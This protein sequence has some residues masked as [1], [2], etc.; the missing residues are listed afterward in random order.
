M[1]IERGIITFV[2]KKNKKL[3]EWEKTGNICYKIKE[4]YTR[5]VVVVFYDW[6]LITKW[7][8]VGRGKK[9]HLGLQRS[10]IVSGDN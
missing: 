5:I 2:W 7:L 3:M 1:K 10:F 9:C 4:K 6:K 8:V